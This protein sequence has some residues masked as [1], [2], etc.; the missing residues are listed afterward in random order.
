MEKSEKKTDIEATQTEE[1]QVY[2]DELDLLGSSRGRFNTK[3]VEDNQSPTPK[4]G[5]GGDL[6]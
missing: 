2:Y 3:E 6:L 4:R 1:T 5:D